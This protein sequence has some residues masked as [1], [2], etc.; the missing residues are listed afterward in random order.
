MKKLI[1]SV[2]LCLL[3]AAPALCET[4]VWVARTDSSVMYIGGTIHLLR[5]S[6]FPLPGEYD[7]AYN[8]ADLLVF[9]TDIAKLS[10]PETQMTMMK[11]AVYAD[12]TTL[13][14][15]LSA[16]TFAELEAYIG[17]TGLPMANL[18][19]MKPSI[20]MITLVGLE[21][22][23]LQ[24]SEKGIDVHYHTKAAAEGKPEAGLE[25]VEEQIEMLT[26]MGEGYEDDFVMFNL[27]EMKVMGEIWETMAEAWR[28]GDDETLA[29]LI[30]EKMKSRFPTL[31]QSIMVDRNMRW[32]PRLEEFLA[33]PETEF[34]LVGAGHLVGEE[35]VL[36]LL[37]KRGYTI[38]KMVIEETTEK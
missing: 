14:D 32:V 25:T 10:M 4:S 33:T 12:S 6:D 20:L 35:G 5:P 8:D 29:A 36:N 18:M 30:I 13:K 34:V 26:T 22:Q 24:V 2:T 7:K 27:R 19:R 21:L 3:M 11:K 23:K 37:K 38:E 31:H 1:V 15:V 28:S 16:E 17:G 9:E